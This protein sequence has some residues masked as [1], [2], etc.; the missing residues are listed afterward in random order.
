MK[1]NEILGINL[2]DKLSVH[3]DLYDITMSP[4]LKF[5]HMPHLIAIGR[6][7]EQKTV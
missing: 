4:G 5:L 7:E 1:I 2:N 3:F 6:K